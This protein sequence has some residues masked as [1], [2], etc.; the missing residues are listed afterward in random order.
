MTANN[1]LN[2]SAYS[3]ISTPWYY[4]YVVEGTVAGYREGRDFQGL[5]SSVVQYRFITALVK[6]PRSYW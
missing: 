6:G 4:S 2:D 3:S 1:L 5:V